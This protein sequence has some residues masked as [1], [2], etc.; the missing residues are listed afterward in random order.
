[1]FP[2]RS[3]E[4][5]RDLGNDKYHAL[6]FCSNSPTIVETFE[7]LLQSMFVW[8]FLVLSYPPARRR[9]AVFQGESGGIGI[10]NVQRYA[11]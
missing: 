4:I 11:S 7:L 8:R 1:M 5:L 3:S 6:S 10:V 2:F 9:V